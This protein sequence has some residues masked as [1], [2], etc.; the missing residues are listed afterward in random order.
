MSIS[1]FKT[2]CI[3]H[4]LSPLDIEKSAIGLNQ[5][6]IKEGSSFSGILKDAVDSGNIGQAPSGD[7]A[8][9]DKKQIE[10]LLQRVEIGMNAHLLKMISDEPEEVSNSIE[11]VFDL[12]SG[13]SSSLSTDGIVSISPHKEQ[14]RDT[15]FFNQDYNDMIKKASETYHV[16]AELIRSVIQVES[17]FNSHS[18][19]SKGAMGLMQLMPETAKDLGV[20]NAY[21]PEENILAG[22]RYLKGLLNRYHGDVR[23]SLAAYNWGMGNVEKYSEKMP[24]ETRNYV[25]RVTANYYRRVE[26]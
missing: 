18:T 7:F 16:D 5:K 11:W 26:T 2:T 23:L 17:N 14:I 22:T 4:Y 19:S 1:S 12:L 24:L 15:H 6:D 10:T 8:S 3:K 25:E 9:L 20:K 21:N 13:C